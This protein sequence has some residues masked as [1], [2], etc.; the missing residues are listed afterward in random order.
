[1]NYWMMRALGLVP[2]NE[3]PAAESP[4]PAGDGG[5]PAAA[6]APAADAPAPAAAPASPSS[7]LG[8]DAP[9]PADAP[10]AEDE[11]PAGA[12]EAYE[13]FAVPEGY[14]LHE[15]AV[16]MLAE[17]FKGLNLTQAQA[18]EVM[19]KIIEIDNARNPTPEQ[20]AQAQEERISQLNADWGQMC[21]E[22]PELGGENFEKSLQIFKM[23]HAIGSAMSEDNMV[24]GGT[25]DGGPKSIEQ[26]LWPTQN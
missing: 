15:A 23:F 26:R 21:R 17:M 24:H 25:P 10:A 16:P 5:A 13:A 12:P 9:K 8:G 18:N 6:P 20:I 11:A 1:M 7:L 3:A 19:A 22:L 4:A 2:M 14:E